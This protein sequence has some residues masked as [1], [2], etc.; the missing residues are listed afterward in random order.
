MIKEIFDKL[1]RCDKKIKQKYTGGDASGDA[2]LPVQTM[3]WLSTVLQL[4]NYRFVRYLKYPFY[5]FWLLI[6]DALQRPRRHP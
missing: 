1:R 2:G 6:L 4:I 5:R 3:R